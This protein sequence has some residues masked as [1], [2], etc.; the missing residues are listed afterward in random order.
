[1]LKCTG[2]RSGGDG[3]ERTSID[4]LTGFPCRF[5]E[6]VHDTLLITNDYLS[7]LRFLQDGGSFADG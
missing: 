1:M 3:S 6:T 2:R 7:Y 4:I 5:C